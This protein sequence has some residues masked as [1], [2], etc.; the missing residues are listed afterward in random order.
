MSRKKSFI[1]YIVIMLIQLAFMLYWAGQKEN[2]IVDELYSMERAASFSGRG[3]TSYYVTLSPE[4]NLNTWIKASELK[5]YFIVTE[6]ESLLN[7]PII[8]A[9]RR[10]IKGRSYNGLL[11]I[12]MSLAGYSIVTARAGILLNLFFFVLAEFFF[13][14]LMNKL[15]LDQ[16]SKIMAFS[17]FG[18]SAYIIGIVEYIRF[19]T[20][21]IAL[22]LAVLNLF[23][24][25]WKNDELYKIILGEV[26]IFV[27]V[28][29]SYNNSELTIPYFSA[30]SIF[31][32]VALALTK[33]WKKIIPFV[34]LI[35]LGVA[36]IATTTE[37]LTV[38]FNPN[39]ETGE[40]IDGVVKKILHPYVHDDFFSSTIKYFITY[41][42][43]HGIILVGVLFAVSI[44]I[45]SH[46]GDVN[47]KFFEKNECLRV[48]PITFFIF[49]AWIVVFAF[50]IY[51]S[52]LKVICAAMLFVIMIIL[53]LELLGIRISIRNH[54]MSADSTFVFV[55]FL[56]TIV[57][58]GLL[59]IEDFDVVGSS[60]YHF[61]SFVSS[62][63][64]F[65]YVVD[66]LI[67]CCGSDKLCKKVKIILIVF[68]VLSACAPF[69]T[70]EVE[71]ILESDGIVKE[72]VQWYDDIKVVLITSTINEETGEISD[73]EV[74]DCLGIISDDSEIYPFDI[75]R[76]EYSNEKFPD[77][78]LLWSKQSWDISEV[79]S[80]LQENGYQ[81][82][83]I[84]KTHMSVA[85][86]CQK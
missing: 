86:I 54:K 4:W 51:I 74:Y 11:N 71:S 44:I 57:Y 28:Y 24:Y 80:D 33:Q 5:K 40:V 46:K 20:L 16:V 69:I 32:I 61:F 8:E 72:Q 75:T 19:Y 83:R 29:L 67:K 30:L 52:S 48:R 3:N 47:N 73:H 39:H 42:F 53:V 60:R 14:L 6:N 13:V 81:I 56:A 22:L 49:L 66:R 10:I 12:A 38:L 1:V 25:V 43:G 23:C 35:I 58:I 59:A 9:A 41:Y 84:G 18:F 68:A 64:I 15:D 50:S 79:L 31:Y 78:F 17:M 77:Y 63:V 26:G 62:M 2:Y 27:I 7:I 65:W 45:I 76:Y 85:Y 36:F 55:L 82:S 37:Y 70:R 34:S 21:V